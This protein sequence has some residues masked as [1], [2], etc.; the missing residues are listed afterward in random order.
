VEAFLAGRIGFLEIVDTIA[1]VVA[2]H[3]PA[4]GELDLD[5]VLAADAWARNE[6]RR[7]L[8]VSSG[9]RGPGEGTA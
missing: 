6:A 7:A 5:G 9:S 2:G 8:S 3:S 4:T 1:Q